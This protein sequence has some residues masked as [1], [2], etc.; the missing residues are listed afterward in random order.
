LQEEVGAIDTSP[1]LTY[2]VDYNSP[3]VGENKF[4]FYEIANEGTA[5]ED[6]QI[7]AS[8]TITGGTGGG[9]GGYLKV[10]YITTSPYRVSE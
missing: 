1:R 7:K 4:V 2:D 10:G 6:K 3:E 9:S 8:F 5:T